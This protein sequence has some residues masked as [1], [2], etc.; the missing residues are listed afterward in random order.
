VLP[1]LVLAPLAAL[2]L[3]NL[4]FKGLGRGLLGGVVLGLA[5]A[6]LALV[7]LNP[8]WLGEGYGAPWDV[9]KFGLSLDHLGRVLLVSIGM[10]V[11]SAVL[12]GHF[13]LGEDHQYR[14]FV[15]LML[16]ALIGMNGTVLLSDLFSLYVFVEITSVASFVLIALE[17][18]K[19]ASE[20]ALKYLLMSA[21]AA[22]ML[23]AAV[24]LFVIYAG[25]TNFEV[26]KRALADTASPARPVAMLAMALYLGGLFIKAG[27]VPFHGWLPAAYSTAP[28]SVSVF[29][30]GI[31]TKA[32]GVYALL[33]LSAY[34]FGPI[35]P[36]GKVLLLVGVV[37]IFV[38]AIA[39]LGQTDLKRMLAYSS[40]SQVGYIVL[41]LGC[42]TPLALAG[43]A[44]H[45][46]N[47][48]TF[49]ALLFSNSA[50]VESRLGT[51]DMTR[52]GGLG[53]QMPVTGVT[54]L[55]ALLS[56]AGIP[57]FS[58][59]WSKLLI[60][61]ALYNAGHD[62]YALL[63]ILGSLFTLG[64]FLVMERTAFFGK[65]PAE[66]EKVT[67]A[68]PGLLVP[69]ILLTLVTV[70]VGVCFPFLLDSFLLLGRGLA[71]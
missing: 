13:T 5:V 31:A 23:L 14:S 70:G 12:V 69:A 36:L 57:P 19:L 68:R 38:G 7:I 39:A 27:L 62:G 3:L 67:E 65:P 9:L 50:A 71:W 32:G 59:F 60:V 64:Y 26:V 58:G 55:I 56:T 51:T 21:V 24:A 41:A 4:P 54:S 8:E 48:A 61:I 29:L 45:V 35:E 53:K 42:G 15:N 20:G 43:A 52:M 1:L 34:V 40:I 30:A 47:H 63:A 37:S 22:T 11:V 28:A 16:V 44:F 46:F 6:Q 17:R 66:M 33:R 2:F 10:V 18:G 25:S 49:K